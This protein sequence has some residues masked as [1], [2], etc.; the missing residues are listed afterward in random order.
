MKCYLLGRV[1][2]HN[3]IYNN[4]NYKVNL[5][6]NYHLMVR[7]STMHCSMVMIHLNLKSIM[8][9]NIKLG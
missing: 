7:I 4:A 5:G 6:G 3:F 9:L 1:V 2:S 8:H